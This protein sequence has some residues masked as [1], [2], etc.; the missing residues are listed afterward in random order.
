VPGKL[1]RR[2]YFALIALL[3]GGDVAPVAVLILGQPDSE[4]NLEA[5]FG[6]D[7]GYRLEPASGRIGS[8]RAGVRRD[9]AQ[10]FADLFDRR[11][12]AQVV[13]MGN[14]FERR[15]GQAGERLVDFGSDLL[16]LEKSPNAGMQA[17]CK[18]DDCCDGAHLTRY[19]AGR[20]CT[21]FEPVPSARPS[22]AAGRCRSAHGYKLDVAI[23]WHQRAAQKYLLHLR[24]NNSARANAARKLAAG[25][26]LRLF[27]GRR[28][29]LWG[30]LVRRRADPARLNALVDLAGGF[31]VDN[32]VG[33]LAYQT[34]ERCLN[35]AARTAEPVIQ[36][37]VAERCIEIIAYQ[38]VDDPLAQ[39]IALRIGGRPGQ[40][41]AH[42]G[43]L[44][45]P[46]AHVFAAAGIL[47]LGVAR[48]LIAP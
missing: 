23:Y 32:Y 5:Q 38:Q 40:L 2:A 31:W 15:I 12:G 4:R 21:R 7:V 3:G 41:A 42:L 1:D 48:L 17:R 9:R 44:V 33:P 34:P 26:A 37:E 18:R 36:V 43:N 28:R 35:M 11:P 45:N 20:N 47:R 29:R 6:R 10:I 13:R 14:P 27:R 22:I 16:A 25:C 8:H 30:R 39:P 24:F 19:R 46:F